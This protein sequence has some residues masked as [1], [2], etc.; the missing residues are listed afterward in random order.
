MRNV[1]TVARAAAGTIDDLNTSE[2]CVSVTRSQIGGSGAM[3][4]PVAAAFNASASQG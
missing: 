4:A 3:V 1:G 2:I